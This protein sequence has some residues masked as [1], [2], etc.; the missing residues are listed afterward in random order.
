MKTTLASERT[1]SPPWDDKSSFTTAE[2]S[3]LPHPTIVLIPSFPLVAPFFSLSS[4]FSQVNC[5]QSTKMGSNAAPKQTPAPNAP[6][7]TPIQSPPAGSALSP[8]PPTLFTPLKIRDVTFQNRICKYSTSML[9]LPANHHHNCTPPLIPF[10]HPT[11][12]STQ[13]LHQC[14]CTP[15]PTAT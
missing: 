4:K 11:N 10:P 12:R 3:Y 9:P 8:D 15:P 7:F 6:Y 5:Y 2:F 1:S 13:G 14:A